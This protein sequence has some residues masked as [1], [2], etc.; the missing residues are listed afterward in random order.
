MR[1][2]CESDGCIVP[3]T[4]TTAVVEEKKCHTREREQSAIHRIDC[5]CCTHRCDARCGEV[6]IMSD[7]QHNICSRE[8]RGSDAHEVGGQKGGIDATVKKYIRS[9]SKNVEE[10]TVTFPEKQEERVVVV[11]VGDTNDT[12]DE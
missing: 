3:T 1:N 7:K 12:T 11:V 4:I 6:E 10:L 8:R 9:S 2:I 5:S